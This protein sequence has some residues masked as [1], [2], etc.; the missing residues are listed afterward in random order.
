MGTVEML[1]L[2]MSI[3]GGAGLTMAGNVTNTVLNVFN[4]LSEIAF[5]NRE[6]KHDQDVEKHDKTEESQTNAR[7]FKGTEGFHK[8]RQ[9]IAKR[10]INCYF[11]I[12]MILPFIAAMLGLPLT[13]TIGYFDITHGWPW[14]E[15]IE[16]VQ[17]ITIGNPGGFPIVITP[18][19]NNAVITIIGMFFG[20]QMVKK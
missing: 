19:M 1:N 8:T 6:Q 20:N 17:W 3:A 9:W 16:T 2:G 15:S 18:V 11:V 13:I 10:V 5:K 14:Q 4:N 7:E 12:P